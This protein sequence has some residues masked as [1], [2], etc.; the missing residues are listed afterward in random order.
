MNKKI[1]KNMLT[2]ANFL[3]LRVKTVKSNFYFNFLQNF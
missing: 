1:F 2:Y 3:T